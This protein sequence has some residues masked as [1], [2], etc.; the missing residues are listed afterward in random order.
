M[1]VHKGLLAA[2]IA[3]EVRN[4]LMAIKLLVQ[5]AAEYPMIREFSTRR[6]QVVPTET[7]RPPSRT[8]R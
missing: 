3:H 8:F 6:R 7:M 1:S 2:G 4:P 5:A